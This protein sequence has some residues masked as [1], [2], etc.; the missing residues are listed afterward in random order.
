MPLNEVVA[1][2]KRMP[3]G[4]LVPAEGMVAMLADTS[5]DERHPPVPTPVAGPATPS[6]W[7]ERVWTV[8]AETRLNVREA[9]EALGRSRD[10]LYRR[11]AASGE[12]TRLPHR[13]RDGRLEFVASDLRAW[14][15]ATER[16]VVPAVPGRALKIARH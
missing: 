8:P 9:A 6:P 7:S 10:W 5:T 12:A 13:V 1:L 3:A 15:T 11:T 2:L 4:T 16:I 14:I